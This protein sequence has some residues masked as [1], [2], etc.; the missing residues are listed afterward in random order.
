[1]ENRVKRTWEQ[2]E[3]EVL[4][5]SMTMEGKGTKVVDIISPSDHDIYDPS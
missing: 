3:L 5:V 4:E 1:M 2:P